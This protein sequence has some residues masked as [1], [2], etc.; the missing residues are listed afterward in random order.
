MIHPFC[1]ILNS[2]QK[3]T[4]LSRLKKSYWNQKITDFIAESS[5]MFDLVDYMSNLRKKCSLI[6]Q[7]TFNFVR[8][9]CLVLV[10]LINI[11]VFAFFEKD[12]RA[13]IGYTKDDKTN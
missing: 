9:T 4:F 3:Q 11:Y 6:S 10:I 7:G 8:D 12:V 1:L 2:S 5:S 13:N